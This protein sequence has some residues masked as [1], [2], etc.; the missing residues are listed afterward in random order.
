[1]IPIPGTTKISSLMENLQGA[2]LELTDDEFRL[3]NASLPEDSP[4]EGELVDQP[5]FRD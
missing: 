5:V 1:M 2:S 3:L 4:L